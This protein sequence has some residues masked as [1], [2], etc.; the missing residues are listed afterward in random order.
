MA[1]PAQ[2]RSI[3]LD[4]DARARRD[5]APAVAP[6]RIQ[7]RDET[8]QALRVH[9]YPAAHSPRQW[10]ADLVDVDPQCL[11]IPVQDVYKRQ[12]WAWRPAYWPCSLRS[13][14]LLAAAN[15]LAS[16]NAKTMPQ[17]MNR[18]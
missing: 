7:W 18:I 17:R 11:P 16:Q 9:A 12:A 13:L 5:R 6:G 4:F 2:P 8:A 14:R 1:K 15:C 3:E 10:G